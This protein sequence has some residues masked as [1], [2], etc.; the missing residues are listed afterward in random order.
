MFRSRLVWPALLLVAF[1]QTAALVW[2]V[3]DRQLH[4]NNGKEIMLDIRPVDPRSLFR[5]DYVILNPEIARIRTQQILSNIKRND[6]VYVVLQAA[7]NGTWSYLSIHKVQPQN[8]PSDRIALRGRVQS[9]WRHG[10][11]AYTSVSLKYGIESYFVPEGTGMALEEQVRKGQI[12][13][14]V[15]VD[16]AGAAAIKGVEVAGTRVVDP[17]LF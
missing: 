7:A 12:R 17:R 14:I 9:V 4:I 16:D 11:A 2:M 6:I 8:L 10:Q 13:A 5:G 1:V 15:A 3:I